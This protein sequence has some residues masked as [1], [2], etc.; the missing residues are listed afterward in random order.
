MEYDG[1]ELDEF[2]D[3]DFEGVT[4]PQARMIN[5]GEEF[6]KWPDS[7]KMTYLKKLAS[8]MN[9]AADIMQQER[10]KLLEEREVIKAQL[11]NTE[12]NL[13]IQKDIVLRTITANNSA[14][15]E[16]I[17]LIQKLEGQ[18]R[19]KDKAIGILNEQV[20]KLS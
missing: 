1:I 11:K 12:S 17:Q 3:L 10:N 4:A 8:S 16:Y 18:V 5:F 2:A 19:S 14:K 15:E 9:H 13:A 20:D 7:R 6:Q